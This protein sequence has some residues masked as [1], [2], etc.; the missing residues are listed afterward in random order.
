MERYAKRALEI[1]SLNA[2]VS[3]I[4]AEAAYS[5]AILG[6]ALALIT[7]DQVHPVLMYCLQLFLAL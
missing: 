3:R 1:P 4:S 5:V 7:N 2:L 6:G